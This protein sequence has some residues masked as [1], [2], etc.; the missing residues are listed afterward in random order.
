MTLLGQIVSG[1][2]DIRN[3]V[4]MSN[5]EADLYL[6]LVNESILRGEEGVY[7]ELSN[8]QVCGVLGISEKTLIDARK[9]LEEKNFIWVVPGD[10]KKSS[11]IYTI[12][13]LLLYCNYSSITS[14]ITSSIKVSKKPIDYC[15]F[16][17][18]FSSIKV[19]LYSIYIYNTKLSNTKHSNLYT[20]RIVT[21]PSI[22]KAKNNIFSQKENQE[23]SDPEIEVIIPEV[24]A[25]PQKKKRGA[26]AGGVEPEDRDQ[27]VT[28]RVENSAYGDGELHYECI[29]YDKANPSMYPKVMYEK[30]LLYWTEREKKGQRRELWRMQ[31]TWETSKRLAKWNQ[32]NYGN[33]NYNN[34]QTGSSYTESTASGLD[35]YFARKEAG[36]VG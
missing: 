32:N 6:F 25:E 18:N 30:F 14:S 16:Y 19:S 13:Y 26:A 10:K 2:Y 7:M 4:K 35:D 22:K 21:K 3:R 23:I 8:A 28:G 27:V 15:S 12:L 36:G 5:I 11:P 1:F 31:K 20:M 17:W 24:V 29:E 34:R 33:S 9:R